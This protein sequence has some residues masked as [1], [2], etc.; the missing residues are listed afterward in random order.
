MS[1]LRESGN[2]EQDADV[3][4]LLYRPH[5]YK[6]D[7]LPD[8]AEINIAKNRDGATGIMELR[9]NEQTASFSDPPETAQEQESFI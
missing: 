9:F 7:E 1:D 4:G 3:I 8:E 5:Y 2:L 6:S